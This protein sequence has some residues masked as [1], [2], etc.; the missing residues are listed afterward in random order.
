MVNGKKYWFLNLLLRTY[1]NSK[2]DY[3]TL[4]GQLLNTFQL[5]NNLYALCNNWVVCNNSKITLDVM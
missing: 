3:C 5:L 2:F 4:H 1:K